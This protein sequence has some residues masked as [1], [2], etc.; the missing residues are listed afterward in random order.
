MK[1]PSLGV[2][3]RALLPGHTAPREQEL[4]SSWIVRLA[5]QNHLKLH[6]FS[7]MLWP[8]AAVWNRDIDNSASSELQEAVAARTGVAADRVWETTLKSYEGIVFERHNP[9]GITPWILP[10]GIY[11]RT[12]VR[13][14]IQFCPDC[15]V[16]KVPYYKKPWRLAWAIVCPVHMRPLLDRCPCGAPV[17]FHRGDLGDREASIADASLTKCYRC[18]TDL[19][20]CVGAS[21]D[22]ALTSAALETQQRCLTAVDL[23]CVTVGTTSIRST[24]FFA[25]LR[26]L[27]QILAT[28]RLCTLLRNTVSTWR[29][30]DAFTPVFSGRINAIERL[31]VEN[32]VVLMASVGEL[33]ADWPR[34]FVRCCQTAGLAASD[35]LKGLDYVPYW[36]ASV[37]DECFGSGAYS[38][39]IAEI[40]AA[41]QYMRKR[42]LVVT[43]TSVSKILGKTD[44]F[45]KRRLHH[46]LDLNPSL[47]EDD[48]T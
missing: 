14:G 35:I 38:P 41:I 7:N 16:E 20:T 5:A 37:V 8:G 19:R 30:I 23:G 44:V 31:P 18:H 15:L 45:R 47:L 25:G 2:G 17:N 26:Q 12:R 32:R 11:H 43:K 24:L 40:G 46:M 28:G 22:L 6:V 13:C 21:F 9:T 27:L 4:F 48:A 3:F 42:E 39:T 10:L 1:H 34:A 33:L 36:L 29:S